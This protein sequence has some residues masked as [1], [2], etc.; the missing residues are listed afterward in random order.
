LQ[1]RTKI[2]QSNAYGF[3]R[4]AGVPIAVR[5]G[6]NVADAEVYAQRTGSVDGRTVQDFAYDVEVP[7]AF[8]KYEFSSASLPV[9]SVRMRSCDDKR[10]QDASAQ[11][12]DRDQIARLETV[13]LLVTL[14]AAE[15]TKRRDVCVFERIGNLRNHAN[16]ELCGQLESTAKLLVEEFVDVELFTNTNSGRFVCEPCGSLIAAA[17]CVEKGLS[18]RRRGQELDLRDNLHTAKLV[19]AHREAT[20]RRTLSVKAAPPRPT[21]PLSGRGPRRSKPERFN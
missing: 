6:G 4:I 8:A 11:R 21:L 16:S 20:Q 1:I 13:D 2:E 17:E 7:A 9:E 19:G 5:I 18:Q 14:D 15:I 3:D 10:N 12:L